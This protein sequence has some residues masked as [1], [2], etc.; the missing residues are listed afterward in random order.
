MYK[1]YYHLR[2]E[3]FNLTPDPRYLFLTARHREAL[4]HLLYGVTQ[5]RGFIRLTGEVGTGKTTLCR[6][7][8]AELG[9]RYHTALILNPALPPGQLLR[10]IVEEFGLDV[11]RGNRLTCLRRLNEFLLTVNSRGQD[12]VLIID[13]AQDMTVEALEMVRLLSNLETE[14]DK[15]LQIVLVGQ[16]ELRGILARP[17]LRQL[18]QRI[19]VCFHLRP[20]DA[21]ETEEYLLHRLWVAG[22]SE[23]GA[24]VRFDRSAVREVYRYSRGTPRLIN[25]VC[26]KA[27]LAGFVHRSNCINSRLVRL[28]IRDLR[29][30]A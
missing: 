12:A 11:G 19:T 3:P 26:D 17:E 29:E 20:L 30:A 18:A 1:D 23:S 14:R 13:E 16:E 6:A 9:P 7:L 27:L 24:P 28:A 5:R 4:D 10:A 8:L 2:Q 21:Q 22:S 15:L 25:V